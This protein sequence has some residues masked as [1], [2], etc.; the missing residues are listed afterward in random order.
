MRG[1]HHHDRLG[2]P[3][4]YPV[5]GE[6][7]GS[8][9][10]PVS[11]PLEHVRSAC[12]VAHLDRHVTPL[13]CRVTHARIATAMPPRQDFRATPNPTIQMTNWRLVEELVLH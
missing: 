2:I 7:N 5:R 4:R 3:R 8:R 11:W 9:G 6:A 1:E 10:A 13:F 12:L